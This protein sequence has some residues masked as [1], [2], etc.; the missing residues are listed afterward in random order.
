MTVTA[1][2][3]EYEVQSNLGAQ[4]RQPGK[5]ASVEALLVHLCLLPAE[6]SI[7]L[8]PSQSQVRPERLLQEQVAAQP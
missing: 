6:D 7:R 1:S 5:E 8:Y 3:L 2:P 4:E